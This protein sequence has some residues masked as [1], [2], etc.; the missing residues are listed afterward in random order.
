MESSIEDEVLTKKANERLD[1][2]KDEDLI[3]WEEAKRLAGWEG[4]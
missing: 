1:Q 2:M 4:E 3:T